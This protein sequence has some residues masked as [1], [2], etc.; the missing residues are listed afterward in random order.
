MEGHVATLKNAKE[1]EVHEVGV[2]PSKEVQPS[3]M[4]INMVALSVVNARRKTTLL[5]KRYLHSGS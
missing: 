2:Q 4:G 5:E 1:K 3:R